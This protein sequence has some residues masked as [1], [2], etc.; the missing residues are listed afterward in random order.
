M[1]VNIQIM[2]HNFQLNA[3]CKRK[4]DV[5]LNILKDIYI[6]EIRLLFQLDNK[7]VKKHCSTKLRV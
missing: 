4:Y 1:T 3:K 5:Y 2:S 6:K 7:K